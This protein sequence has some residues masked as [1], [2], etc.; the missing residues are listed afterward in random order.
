MY[1]FVDFDLEFIKKFRSDYDIR[2]IESRINSLSVKF[3]N[4]SLFNKAD[5]EEYDNLTVLLNLLIYIDETFADFNVFNDLRASNLLTEDELKFEEY[6]LCN[7]IEY[8]KQSIKTNFS[9]KLEFDELQAILE[10][11]PGVGGEEASL[12][13]EEIARAYTIYMTR[14]GMDFMILSKDYSENGTLK[15]FIVHITEKHAYGELRFES[16][17]FRVQRI[18]ITESNGRIHTSTIIFTVLPFFQSQDDENDVKINP[19]DIRIDTFR[20]SGAGG[21]SVNTTDSAVRIKHL[22]SGIIVTCQNCKS[23]HQ[24]KEYAL[25]ILKSKLL[26]MKKEEK[27]MKQQSIKQQISHNVD[28]SFKTRTFNFP[29]SRIT[30]HRINKSWFN[31]EEFMEGNIE[32]VIRDTRNILR[33]DL[34]QTVK[35]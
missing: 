33:S 29:Q 12:F 15:E 18:P 3:T 6:A 24:N 26:Q 28:R 20:S 7:R 30:D 23:Q 5:V 4:P 1:F 13:A 11:R 32:E 21:Q 19:E 17:I 9:K 31:I 27:L 16:G 10:I 2:E 22:P 35:E 8:I 25:R 34:S 14:K